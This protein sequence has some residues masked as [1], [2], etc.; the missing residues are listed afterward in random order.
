ML[1]IDNDG[2]V[3]DVK[4]SER[5]IAFNLLV[6]SAATIMSLAVA[7]RELPILVILDF[8]KELERNIE[9]AQDN[10]EA[11]NKILEAALASR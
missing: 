5:D 10:L 3:V 11:A 9:V 1:V 6:I 8:N 7:S 4:Q 2:N